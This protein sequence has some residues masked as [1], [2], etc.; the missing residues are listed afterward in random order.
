MVATAYCG[1]RAVNIKAACTLN[2]PKVQA[3]FVCLATNP[4]Q[5]DMFEC[6][7]LSN[8]LYFAPTSSLKSCQKARASLCS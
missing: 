3:A 8:S 7:L 4:N 6:C 2:Q 5:S 1:G